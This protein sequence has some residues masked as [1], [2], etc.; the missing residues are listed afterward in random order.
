MTEYNLHKVHMCTEPAEANVCTD[1]A[2]RLHM[3]VPHRVD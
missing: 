3:Q 2:E 1:S